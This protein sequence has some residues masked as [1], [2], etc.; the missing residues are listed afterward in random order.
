MHETLPYALTCARNLKVPIFSFLFTFVILDTYAYLLWLKEKT[1]RK[2][3][4][5]K[6][7][8]RLLENVCVCVFI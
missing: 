3:K 4:I 7:Q 6:L 1:I 2:N 8:I 5:R